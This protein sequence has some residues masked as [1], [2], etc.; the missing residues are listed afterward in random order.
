VVSHQARGLDVRWSVID[1]AT[2]EGNPDDLA[3]VVNILLEN[4]RRH[5][6]DGPVDVVLSAAGD[7]VD[8]EV[9]DAGPGVPAQ[10]RERIFDSG[11]RS[12]ESPGQGL[13]LSIARR[14]AGD[15]GGTLELLATDRPGATF[16]LRLLSEVPDVCDV[17]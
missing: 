11:E 15:L 1:D 16:I 10:L 2:C 14:L 4:A 3:E 5:G 8:I 7:H 13:G 12:P 17:A 9:S 6:G